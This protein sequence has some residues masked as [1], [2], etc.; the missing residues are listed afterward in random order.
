VILTAKP[1]L[2]SLTVN[3]GV[4]LAEVGVEVEVGVSEVVGV[5]DA[6]VLL[7]FDELHPAKTARDIIESEKTNND[8]FI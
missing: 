6:G 1:V 4:S 2:P 5:T 7:V 3:A 8:F